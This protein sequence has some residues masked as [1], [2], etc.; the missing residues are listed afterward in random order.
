MLPI[1]M[2]N[3]CRRVYVSAQLVFQVRLWG[4]ISFFHS[5][6]CHLPNISSGIFASAIYWKCTGTRSAFTPVPFTID[7]QPNHIHTHTPND[8]RWAEPVRV[9]NI[10]GCVS[11]YAC[12]CVY[13][14]KKVIQTHDI[15]CTICRHPNFLPDTSIVVYIFR[16]WEILSRW[17]YYNI[18][19][20]V[21]CFIHSMAAFDT[22]WYTE[23]AIDGEKNWQIFSCFRFLERGKNKL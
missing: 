4:L 15:F 11:S 5:Q 23:H 10:F 22:A 1:W 21:I 8:I 2:A 3:D 9:H 18:F 20:I 19:F 12:V 16:K 14:G 17:S 7:E 13:R 6:R